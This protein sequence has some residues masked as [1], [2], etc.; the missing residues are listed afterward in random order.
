VSEESAAEPATVLEGHLSVEAALQAGARPVHRILAVRPGD[1]RLGRLRTLA[2]ER[3]VIIERGTEEEVAAL[4]SGR[5]HGGVVA[6]VGPRRHLSIDELLATA[7]PTPFLVMLDGIEDPYNFGAAVRA[8]YA[9]DVDGVV[10]RERSWESAAGVVGRASAGAAELMRTATVAS[11][12]AAADASRQHG[13]RVLC[14]AAGPEAVPMFGV[15]LRGPSFV[16]I[17]GERRGITRSFLA[18]A[19]LLVAVPYGR[20][21]APPLGTAAAAAL[22]A[23]EALRQ[24]SASEATL[25]A[26]ASRAS[27]RRGSD[28]HAPG[29]DAAPVRRR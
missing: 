16:L 23:F 25:P 3:G 19:D 13:L 29:S 18:G 1:R 6:V 2:R 24:R 4:A 14:A 15:D 20:P 22:I 10:V 17:G 9:A 7:G 8:L 11:A 12:E 27:P 26:S 21:D 28:R 5:T